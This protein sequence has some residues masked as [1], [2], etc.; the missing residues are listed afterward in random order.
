LRRWAE[1]LGLID[2]HWD[3]L[4]GLSP[5]GS[6]GS[7]EPPLSSLPAWRLRWQ[8]RMGRLQGWLSR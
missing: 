2:Q 8:Q 6:S 1:A 4:L 5:G 7:G 3:R